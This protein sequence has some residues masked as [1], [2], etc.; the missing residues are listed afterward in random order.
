VKADCKRAAGVLII[1]SFHK[2]PQVLLLGAFD[3]PASRLERSSFCLIN[4]GQKDKKRYHSKPVNRCNHLTDVIYPR[5]FLLEAA[6]REIVRRARFPSSTKMLETK[7]LWPIAIE[8]S[9]NRKKG[10]EAA[11]RGS[12]K[13]LAL[14][15]SWRPIMCKDN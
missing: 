9:R 10:P 14:G 5:L 3:L 15:G 1:E 8:A 11:F 2:L 4:A 6:S 12:K 13:R 7:A